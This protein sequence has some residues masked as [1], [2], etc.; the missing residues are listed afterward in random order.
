MKSKLF[1]CILRFSFDLHNLK[2]SNLSSF[3]RVKNML[4]TLLFNVHISDEVTSYPQEQSI[5]QLNNSEKI[6]EQW[7]IF[8]NELWNPAP[9]YYLL[10]YLD[11]L[12]LIFVFF[13]FTKASKSSVHKIH[14]NY[15][16]PF[17]LSVKRKPFFS[18]YK[19]VFSKRKVY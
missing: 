9:K 4:F 10:C 16:S 18:R 11:L 1:R 2:I 8:F 13:L 17:A 6:T 12:F 3:L 14:F 15:Y 7:G 19:S 5:N